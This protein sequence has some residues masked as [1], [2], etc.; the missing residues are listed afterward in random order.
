MTED[1][2][3]KIIR[4]TYLKN[5]KKVRSRG[6]NKTVRNQKDELY[7]STLAKF[8]VG[9]RYFEHRLFRTIRYFEQNCRSLESRLR[10]SHI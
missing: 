8:T 1:L 4:Q 5:R 6:K 3:Y 7:K 2:K 10:N 9:T